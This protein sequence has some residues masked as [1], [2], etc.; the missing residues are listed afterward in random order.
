MYVV[1]HNGSAVFGGGELGTV[2]LLDGL[3]RRGHR[4]L[5]L[6]R[7]ADMAAR[8]ATYGIPTS[9]QRI[10][11]S[12]MVPDA[13]AFAARL[14][15]ERPDAL[16]LTSFKKVFLAGL[17]ARM[18][19]TP[20]VVQRIVL[21]SDTP[22]R[23]ATYRQAFRHYVDAI[24]LNADS[25]RAPFLAG[26]PRL[27]AAKV[28]TI[29]DGV[30]APPRAAP[31]G[32]VR[33]ELAI[34]AGARVIGAIARLATQKRFDRLLRVLSSLPADVYC[35]LAG[36]GEE[37]ETLEG[38]ARSLGV[39]ARVR[40]TGFRRDVGDV[41]AAMDVFVVSSDREGMANAM[42]EALAAGVPVVSTP[43]SGAME[44]L[45]P[46]ADGSA[47]GTVTGFEDESV[48]AAVHVLLD[49]AERRQAMA[50]AAT[51]R[52]AERFSF[53][54]MVTRWEELLFPDPKP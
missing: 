36:E 23:R 1:A 22:A 19:R 15:R 4:T 20:R 49:D 10:G 11:G 16:L 9:V 18:A 2:R 43:V 46:F 34:P 25:I 3:A 44:A 50:A 17:G 37:R 52:A 12:V 48:L 39:A 40:F 42:L 26:D 32:A 51:R 28:V 24:A 6:F 31:D 35:I 27:D 13:F 38:L 54:A 47:P 41:L 7:D 45:E 21:Q 8:A 53:D 14:R 33:N 29:H 5:M 30:D